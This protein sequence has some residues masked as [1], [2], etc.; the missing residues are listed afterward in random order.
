MYT[1]VHARKLNRRT[2]SF[3]W[4]LHPLNLDLDPLSACVSVRRLGRYTR[5]P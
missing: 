3:V 5:T 1:R 2:R 4:T